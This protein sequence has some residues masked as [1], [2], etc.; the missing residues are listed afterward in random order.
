MDDL[1]REL[2]ELNTLLA[3]CRVSGPICALEAL[4]IAGAYTTPGS[5]IINVGS[6]IPGPPGPQGEKGEQGEQGPPGPAGPPGPPGKRGPQGPP[7]TQGPPGPPGECSCECKTLLVSEDYTV[8]NTDYYIGVNSD[9]PVTITLPSN[10]TD[11]HEVII[12][13][14]MGPPLGNRKVTVVVSNNGTIDGKLSYVMTV[15]YES[16]RLI[17]RGNEWHII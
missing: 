8:S 12:K 2:I 5:D 16:V 13:A 9:G 4:N 7:G 1:E 6:V 14:E 15:P 11:C 3:R 10:C 17:C